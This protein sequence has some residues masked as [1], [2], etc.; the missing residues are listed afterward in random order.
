M[1]VVIYLVGCV[2]VVVAAAAAVVVVVVGVVVGSVGVVVAM[3]DI[4]G[5]QRTLAEQM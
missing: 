5:S 3:W 4:L 2:V 1:F